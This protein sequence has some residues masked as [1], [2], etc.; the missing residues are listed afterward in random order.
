MKLIFPGSFPE[1]QEIVARIS[2]GGRWVIGREIC[3]YF[4]LNGPKIRCWR[5]SAVFVQGADG[6]AARLYDRLVH[7]IAQVHWPEEPA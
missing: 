5:N 6:P 2:P 1:L 7:E 4:T 3:E